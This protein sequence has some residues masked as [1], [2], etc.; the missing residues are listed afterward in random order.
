MK[1]QL[2]LAVSLGFSLI[3]IGLLTFI[4]LRIST[5]VLR[6]HPV[7]RVFLLIGFLA[8]AWYFPEGL[9][10]ILEMSGSFFTQVYILLAKE[11][12][13]TD[14]QSPKL[15]VTVFDSRIWYNA[16]MFVSGFLL[17]AIILDYIADQIGHISEEAGTDL[18]T[19]HRSL[20]QNVIA[21]AVLLLALYFSLSAIIAVP[22]VNNSQDNPSSY[23]KDLREELELYHT[24]DSTI[25]KGYDDFMERKYYLLTADTG[26]ARFIPVTII[27]TIRNFKTDI[28]TAF[29]DLESL[30]ARA[31][32]RMIMT[33]NARITDRL[34][35]KDK[36]ELS[37][38]YLDNRS[39]YIASLNSRQAAIDLLTNTTLLL[40]EDLNKGNDVFSYGSIQLAISQIGKASVPGPSELPQRPTLGSDLGVFTW[41]T[42]WLLSA[43]SFPLVVIIGLVGFGLLGAATATFVREKGKTKKRVMLEDLPGVLIKGFTAAIVI[44]LGVQGSLAVLSTGDGNPNAYA[45]FFVVFVAAVFSDDAWNW[46]KNRFDKDLGQTP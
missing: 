25:R 30:R 11:I 17:V 32:A 27:E 18:F 42:G 19:N 13:E 28:N 22:I 21:V 10:T 41:F 39:S 43:E 20:I 46:A 23:A 35:T 45:M 12:S 26:L 36:S 8:T 33:D 9:K 24:N 7:D 38:W 5:K 2:L 6:K 40:R 37:G 14:I 4:L 44:F 31:V 34:K 15:I 29:G 16:L 3:G 1:N